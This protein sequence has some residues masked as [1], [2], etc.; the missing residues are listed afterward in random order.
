[1]RRNDIE[2]LERC[3]V[4]YSDGVKK[5]MDEAELYEKLLVDFLT[6]NTFEE[7]RADMAA[8]DLGAAQKAVHAMKSVTGTLCMY[9]LYRYCARVVDE[10]RAG[11]REQAEDDMDTAYSLYRDICS[12]IRAVLVNE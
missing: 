4:G 2:R 7:S 3:G 9:K 11:L 5:F 6:D 10:L 1:M 12:A 8:G